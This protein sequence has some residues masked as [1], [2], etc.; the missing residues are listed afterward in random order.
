M[1]AP[2]VRRQLRSEG[3]DCT[4]HADGVIMASIVKP[5]GE[6]WRE[7]LTRRVSAIPG[8]IVHARGEWETADPGRVRTVVRFRLGPEPAGMVG[9]S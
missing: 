3:Y 6:A 9:L 2:T 1:D 4:V 5:R 7:A 8:A